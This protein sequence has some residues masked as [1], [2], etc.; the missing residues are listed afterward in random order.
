MSTDS[1]DNV[2]KRT[3]STSRS[4]ISSCGEKISVDY[5]YIRSCLHSRINVDKILR[6]VVIPV[7]N[8]VKWKFRNN[9]V[10]VSGSVVSS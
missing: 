9:V 1:I 3:K 5:F 7:A 4:L 8:I 6:I 2:H 10:E